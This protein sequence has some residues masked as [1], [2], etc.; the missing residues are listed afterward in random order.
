MD[1][2]KKL[3][4]LC[5]FLQKHNFPGALLFEC[6]GIKVKGGYSLARGMNFLLYRPLLAF[7]T[8]DETLF[9]RTGD[10]RYEFSNVT[11][12]PFSLHKSGVT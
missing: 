11:I 5:I 10:I 2:F 8:S 12:Q 7:C 9:T 3:I 1:L 6:L 4:L